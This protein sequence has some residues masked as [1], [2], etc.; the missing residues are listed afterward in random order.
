MTI[1][2]FSSFAFKSMPAIKKNKPASSRRQSRQEH[3]SSFLERPLPEADEVSRF[4]EAVKKEALLSEVDNNL[5]AIYHDNHGKLVDVSK[6]KKRHRLRLIVLFKQLFVLT[7]VACGL[8]GAYYY[9]FQMPAGNDGVVLQVQAPE[10]TLAAAPVTYDITY[11]N[12]SGLVLSGAKLEVVL[13]ANFVL[14]E[15]NPSVSGI[16][17]WFLGDLAAGEMGH[18]LLTGYLIA[19]VDSANVVTARLSY[20]PANFS[21][22]FKKEASANT[23][24]AGLGFNVDTDY[25]NTALIG[26]DNEIKLIFSGFKDNHLADF[27]LEASGSDNF[28][29]KMASTS[30]AQVSSSTENVDADSLVGQVQTAGTNSWLLTYMPSESVERVV[31][32]VNFSLNNKDKD[33]EDLHLRLFKKENDGSERTFWE[34]TLSFEAMKSD[35]NISLELN[36]AKSDQSVDFG[37]NLEYKLFYSNNGGSSLYDLVLM[38]VVKSDVVQWSSLRDPAGG[39]VSSNAIVWTKEQVPALAELSPGS[40]GE[41]SFSLKLK[42]F[43]TSNLG[44]EAVLT[45]YAQYGLNNQSQANED[46]KSNTIKSQLNS[47]LSL[48]EKILYFNEDNMPVG[49]GPLPPRVGE[50]TKVRVFWTVKNNLHDLDNTQV[51][52]DLPAGIEWSAGGSTNVGS[53]SYS[54]DDRRITWRL[55]YLPLSVY[56]ADA[57]FNLSLTPGESDLDKI[58]VISPGSV[59]TA[60][61]AVTKSE[62][63]R[64]TQAK[65]TK[66]EDDEIAGLSNNGRVE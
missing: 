54:Q 63:R 62:L 59:V 3:L 27:Y 65:T 61:D 15:T 13:P 17:S 40:S 35:L 45:S 43:N 11:Q 47:D 10:K 28:K 7:I 30:S 55:G 34:K 37:S 56:R 42:D 26:E 20:T 36:G 39:T 31:V 9:Y 6:V 5:S 21:S 12:A 22:E 8:Y 52:L 32:P 58:L 38:A 53:I 4:E 49:S 64:K 46:N 14:V 66:L 24:I 50:T 19:P 1:L 23:V 29:I 16:N 25:L 41:I 2:S 51:T 60:T 44:Q 48:S 33:K 18:V 57:E